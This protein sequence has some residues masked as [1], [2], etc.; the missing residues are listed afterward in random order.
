LALYSIPSIPSHSFI[1]PQTRAPPAQA[2]PPR[3]TVKLADQRVVEGQPLKLHCKVEADPTP[4]LVW[5]KD[6]E[7]V[8][9]SERIQLERDAD[10]N[11]YLIIPKSTMDDDGVIQ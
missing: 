2:Q 9:P 5:Y 3:I 6:G 7:Q 1:H 8:R 4:E 10:G 11:A